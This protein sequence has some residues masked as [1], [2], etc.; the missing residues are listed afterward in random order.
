M[1][2]FEGEVKHKY[3][4]K[5]FDLFSNMFCAMPIAHCINKQI[6]IVHGGLFT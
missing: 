3:D 5:I 4:V 1:Y 2:G 6:L